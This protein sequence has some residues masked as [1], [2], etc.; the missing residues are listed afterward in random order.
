MKKIFVVFFLAAILLTL[1][2]NTAVIS[3]DVYS[4]ENI[5]E[6]DKDSP[7]LFITQAQYAK[8][9]TFIQASFQGEVKQEAINIVKNVTIYDSEE[10]HYK[11]NMN[12]LIQAV[13]EHS[14]YKI[15]SESELA[16]VDTKSKLN[17]LINDRWNFSARP[18]GKLINEIINLIK[19]GW[20]GYMNC[21]IKVEAF[22]SRELIWL[23]IL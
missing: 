1:P 13:K 18:L 22:L 8:L 3:T 2:V 5:S 19:I 12:N 7:E 6:K 23:K 20:V 15:I 14:Y 4:I 9:D 17:Q 10:K 11:I 16:E 21:F